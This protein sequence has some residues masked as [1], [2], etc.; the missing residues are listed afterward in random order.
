MNLYPPIRRCNN[1]DCR[2]I[3]NFSDDLG[4][5][6]KL[7]EPAEYKATL[8]TKDHGTVPIH[9]ISY[10][11]RCECRTLPT[12]CICDNLSSACN[13]RF[14][15][16]YYVHGNATTRTYYAA[17]MLEVVQ[18]SRHVYMDRELCENIATMMATAWYVLYTLGIFFIS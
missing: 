13:T 14:Y 9:V 17:D 11:C 12:R 1:P 18:A 5:E 15:P 8:F 6:R 7:A 3:L 2:Y 10:Y 4:L 16:N